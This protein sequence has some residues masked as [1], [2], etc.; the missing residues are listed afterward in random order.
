MKASFLALMGHR[1]II[2]LGSRGRRSCDV[3]F[4]KVTEGKYCSEELLL[5]FC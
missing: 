2:Y 5:F 3:G 4:M 1:E